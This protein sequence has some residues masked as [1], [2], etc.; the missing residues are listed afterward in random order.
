MLV[1]LTMTVGLIT[2]T[3]SHAQSE[4]ELS[5]FIVKAVT[6]FA[7]Q[8]IQI[9]NPLVHKKKG[10][11]MLYRKGSFDMFRIIGK[12]YL[13]DSLNGIWPLTCFIADTNIIYQ[14]LP[15]YDDD[16]GWTKKGLF[17]DLAHK[18]SLLSETAYKMNS[19]QLF[20]LSE[21]IIKEFRKLES[22]SHRVV[23]VDSSGVAFIFYVTSIRNKWYITVI[24][25]L[26][27]DNSA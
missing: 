27:G 5:N 3:L 14:P 21:K 7:E 8:D 19:S 18:D 12:E 4:K 6:A 20:S 23:L 2:L 9:I 26:T 13:S 16:R 10:L 11:I 25:R 22:Q 24:D 1:F 17:C 15:V